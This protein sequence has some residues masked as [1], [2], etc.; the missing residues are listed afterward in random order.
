LYWDETILNVR[1]PFRLR[2]LSSG[3]KEPI[4]HSVEARLASNVAYNDGLRAKRKETFSWWKEEMESEN[5]EA[6]QAGDSG[7]EREPIIMRATVLA[8]GDAANRYVGKGR[9][10]F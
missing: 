9:G 4:I 2:P 1:N 7:Q 6:F 5:V 3:G 10:F 8:T